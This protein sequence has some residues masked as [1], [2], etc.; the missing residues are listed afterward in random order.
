MVSYKLNTLDR[1]TIQVT[2]SF[3]MC[4]ILLVPSQRPNSI[5]LSDMFSRDTHIPTHMNWVIL[6]LMR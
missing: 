3:L 2:G 4:L 5:N 6:K 1:N